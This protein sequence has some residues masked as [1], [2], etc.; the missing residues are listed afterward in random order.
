MKHSKID[1]LHKSIKVVAFE[2]NVLSQYGQYDRIHA[3]KK[4]C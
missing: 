3:D 4:N 1:N 2:E